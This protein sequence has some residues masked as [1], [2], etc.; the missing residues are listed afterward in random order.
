[1][2]RSIMVPRYRIRNTAAKAIIGHILHKQPGYYDNVSVIIVLSKIIEILDRI[3][4]L[5]G[6]HKVG[7]ESTGREPFLSFG[8]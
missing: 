3:D 2:I 1:M 7:L 8:Q 6:I 4:L 5:A